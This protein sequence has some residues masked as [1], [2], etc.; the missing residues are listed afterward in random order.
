[1]EFEISDISEWKAVVA[2]IK[3]E[4]KHPLILLKGNLGA[5]KTTFTQFL[6][7]SMGNKEDISSPTYALVNEYHLPQGTV[8]HFDLYR[9]RSPEEAFDLGIEEYLERG[10]LT[11]IEWPEIYAEE[12]LQWPHHTL[13]IE[14]VDT[15]RRV[16]F[17]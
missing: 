5:G 1:M 15:G 7:Q 9:L 17:S 11:L 4:L 12:L 3:A 6:L 14:V 13:E 2:Q 16:R 8:F 10:F